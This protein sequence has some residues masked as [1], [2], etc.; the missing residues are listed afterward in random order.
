MGFVTLKYSPETLF[1]Q[2]EQTVVTSQQV[3]F[4]KHTAS[5][6][7]LPNLLPTNRSDWIAHA[8]T[9]IPTTYNPKSHVNFNSFSYTHFIIKAKITD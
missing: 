3:S 6:K 2:H 4:S 7:I 5:Q 1:L 8:Q 9:K